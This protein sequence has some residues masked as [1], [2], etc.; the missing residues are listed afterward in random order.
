MRS[1]EQ[2]LAKAFQLTLGVAAGT[3]GDVRNQGDQGV[4][5]LSKLLSLILVCL[6]GSPKN[7]DNQNCQKSS[8]SGHGGSRPLGPEFEVFSQGRKPLKRALHAESGA[9]LLLVHSQTSVFQ[10]VG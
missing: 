1:P 5:S 10:A 9:P 2:D 3:K 8:D 4:D 6:Q 7:S